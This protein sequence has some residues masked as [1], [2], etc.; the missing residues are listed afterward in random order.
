MQELSILVKLEAGRF[1]VQKG[2]D[3]TVVEN[4]P[5]STVVEIS[6]V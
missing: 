3:R 4:L 1:I 6:N 2:R 5:T